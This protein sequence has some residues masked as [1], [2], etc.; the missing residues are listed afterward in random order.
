MKASK[1]L[2]SM[3]IF[4]AVT[5]YFIW[6]S[7]FSAYVN[8]VS[9]NEV[10]TVFDSL[11]MPPKSDLVGGR[12]SSARMGQA[13]VMQGIRFSQNEDFVRGFYA[14]NMEQAGWVEKMDDRTRGILVYCRSGIGA[15]IYFPKQPGEAYTLMAAWVKAESHYLHCSR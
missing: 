14:K 8:P 10:N 11:P 5:S 15:A 6:A 12:D 1:Q 2:L 3:A 4:V 9:L 13:S 7:F